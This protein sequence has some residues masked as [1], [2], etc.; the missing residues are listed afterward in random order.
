MR[1]LS[2]GIKTSQI[3]IG[4]EEILST[5]RDADRIPLFE[6]AWL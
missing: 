4:Y 5:W 2:F 3:G 6:H 1:P